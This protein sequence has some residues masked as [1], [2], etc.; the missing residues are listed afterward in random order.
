MMNKKQKQNE[1]L[2]A[3]NR[4]Y[5]LAFQELVQGRIPNFELFSEAEE[6]AKQAQSLTDYV[7]CS[8]CQ[9]QLEVGKDNY[10]RFTLTQHM[11]SSGQGEVN[12]PLKSNEFIQC[13]AC[14]KPLTSFLTKEQ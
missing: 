13:L 3:L 2:N 11:Q 14:A 4:A 9:K 7:A 8:G 10:S 5:G 1:A 6:L 12:Q